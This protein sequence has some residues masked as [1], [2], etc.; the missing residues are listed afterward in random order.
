M[1]H[2]PTSICVSLNE[3]TGILGHVMLQQK[4]VPKPA[5]QIPGGIWHADGFS[6]MRPGF[7]LLDLKL[8]P[9]SQ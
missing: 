3:Y 8:L 2:I 7:E 9:Q 5:A 6:V 1:V 4:S